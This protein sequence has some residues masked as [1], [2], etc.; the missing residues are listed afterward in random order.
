M[1]RFYYKWLMIRRGSSHPMHGLWIMGTPGIFRMLYDD[2]FRQKDCRILSIHRWRN[3]H[4][5]GIAAPIL[6]IM[7]SITVITY[8]RCTDAVC[9]SFCHDDARKIRLPGIIPCLARHGHPFF[10]RSISPGGGRWGKKTG[11]GKEGQGFILKHDGEGGAR[12]ACNVAFLYHASRSGSAQQGGR[13]PNNPGE[14][15]SGSNKTISLTES[16]LVLRTRSRDRPGADQEA[17]TPYFSADG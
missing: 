17:E 9:V 3:H 10:P 5:R 13:P 16:P 4:G 6:H 8:T 1:C 2:A 12:R 11:E 14:A 15:V 7:C